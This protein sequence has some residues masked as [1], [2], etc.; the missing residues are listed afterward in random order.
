MIDDTRYLGGCFCG[1]VRYHGKG[2]VTN[3][4]FCHCDTC[5]R[6]AGATPV[7][8]GTFLV[9][10]FSVVNGQLAESRSSAK[11]TRGFCANCGTSLTYRHDDRPAEIDVTLVSLDEPTLLAPEDHIWVQDKLPWIDIADGRPQYAKFR[12][13]PEI[14]SKPEA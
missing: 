6:I 5:R 11:V 10:R 14:V 3:L 4:C 7:A 12:T 2:P 8:W 1:L 9:Q 13:G